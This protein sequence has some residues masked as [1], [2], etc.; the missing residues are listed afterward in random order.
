MMRTLLST[1]LMMAWMVMN[2]SA[3]ARATCEDLRANLKSPNA[4]TR[5][6]AAGQLGSA[7]CQDSVTSLA[8]LVRDPEP[9][10]RLA[11]VKALRE[12]RD[13]S[14][15]PALTT[16]LGDGAPEIREEAIA[17]LAEVYTERDRPAAVDRLLGTF[18]DDIDTYRVPRYVQVDPGVIPALARL[19]QDEVAS[20]RRAAAQAI[21]VLWGRAAVPQLTSAL[22][23]P[24]AAVRAEV[25]TAMAKAATPAEGRV[26]TPVIEDE[27]AAVRM[28]VLHAL[29]TLRVKEAGPALRAL[30]E[31]N[32][33]REWE[34]R[35]LDAMARVRD[36]GLR[37]LFL[38]LVQDP[39]ATRRRFAVEGLARISDASMVTAF[40]KD[41]QRESGDELRLA[42]CFALTLL[43][44]R[45][46]IDSLV[47]TL[48]RR[49][50]GRRCRDYLLEMGPSILPE[51]FPYLGD[52]SADVRAELA[53]L[54]SAMEAPEALPQLER[55]LSDPNAGVVDRATRAIEHLRRY[56]AAPR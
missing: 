43:G 41:Y 24:D 51:L 37:D 12:I 13:T 29:G 16:F 52:P 6:T 30:W 56:G 49:P 11:V 1:A 14:S 15:A 23:D 34:P 55:L 40:K 33:R 48:P 10:V 36:P 46:F 31:A 19:L 42:Y 3:M 27:S 38:G 7:R 47:L 32:K 54:F 44:D 4:R 18:S 22:A 25:V 2:G 26:L 20:V 53:D 45:A 39:D 28:R 5:E 9:K 17:A 8:A 21:G 50:E 35:I